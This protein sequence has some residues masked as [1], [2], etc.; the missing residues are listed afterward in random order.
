VKKICKS[1]VVEGTRIV[2]AKNIVCVLPF[3][4][5][6]LFGQLGHAVPGLSFSL[7]DPFMELEPLALSAS[8]RQWLEERGE[9][10]VGVVTADYEPLDILSDHNRYEGI[11]A[12]YLSLITGKLSAKVRVVG[13]SKPGDAM[14]ALLNGEIDIITSANSFERGNDALRLSKGYLSDR[15]VVVVRRSGRG[16]TLGLAGS[17]VVVLEGYEDSQALNLAYP[18]AEIITAPNLTSAMEAVSQGDVDAFI[19]NEIIARSYMALRPYLDLKILFDSALPLD[20]FSFA[21]RK[22]ETRLLSLIDMALAS[23]GSTVSHGVLGRWTLGLGADI[24]HQR[25]ALNRAERAWI[26]RHPVVTVASPQQPPYIYRD[27]NG[28]WLGLNVDILSR[29]SR[30]TGLQFVH[31][32]TATI[33]QTYELL[34]TARAQM[35]TTFGENAE[36]RKMLDFTYSFGGNSWVF[37]VRSGSSSPQSLKELAGQT[38]AL[39]AN[40]VLEGAIRLGNPDIDLLL[41]DSYEDARALVE[42]GA[43]YAT[44]QNEAG[45]HLSPP[46]ALK[47]GRSVEGWWSPDSFSV[48]KSQPELLS[49]LNK[50]LEEFPVGEMRATRAKWLAAAAPLPSIWKRIPNWI[51]WLLIIALMMVLVSLGWSSRLKLQIRQQL[52]ADEALGDQLAFMHALLNGIPSPIY[53]RDLTGRLISC[54]RSYEESVGISFEQMSGRRLIDIELFPRSCAKQLHADYLNLLENRQPIFVDRSMQLL[55][56]KIDAWQWTVPFYRADG[57]LQ[58]LLGGWIDITERKQLEC[59]LKEAQEQADQASEAK[60]RFIANMNHEVR[61][62]LGLIVDLLEREIRTAQ[63]SGQLPS[64]GLEAAHQ[65]ARA[66]LELIAEREAVV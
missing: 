55:G 8:D 49:I 19:G 57:Q 38:L 58:G 59:R 22:E 11:S 17:K 9:L 40:H 54:N 42:S 47:V 13:Y 1:G 48:I 20:A 56:R 16:A 10:R 14:G 66:L 4:L 23:L 46:G 44:I 30:L 43:A 27:S 15:S 32:E 18:D 50:V 34:R 51:Y 31:E 3:F 63:C 5:F 35:N 37:V 21:V 61:P 45:A 62:P 33:E 26:A 6:L 24:G 60:S 25:I 2:P 29:V 53:V 64:S 28:Q 36:R 52:K 65:S 12:D 39:P 41:V 7:T